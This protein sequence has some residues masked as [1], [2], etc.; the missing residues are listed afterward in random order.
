LLFYWKKGRCQIPFL[1]GSANLPFEICEAIP[2]IGNHKILIIMHNDAVMQGLSQLP[3]MKDVSIWGIYDHRMYWRW[4]ATK[5]Q[6]A[7]LTRIHA[8]SRRYI[9]NRNPA[10]DAVAAASGGIVAMSWLKATMRLSG[11]FGSQPITSTVSPIP[12]P[13]GTLVRGWNYVPTSDVALA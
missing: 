6:I 1:R 12:G 11:R 9:R 5:G 3:F 10:G 13:H 4:R 7:Q 2:R 8:Y